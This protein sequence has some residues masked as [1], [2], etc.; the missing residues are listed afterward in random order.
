[1]GSGAA[2]QLD[3]AK[4]VHAAAHPSLTLFIQEENC[5]GWQLL[6]FSDL[7][8]CCLLMVNCYHKAQHLRGSARIEA[9]P[10]PAT[11]QDIL[12]SGP[13]AD[14]GDEDCHFDPVYS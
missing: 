5:I 9:S 8:R 3:G 6:K 12:A 1:M 7:G 14:G 10:S 4:L 13:A 11:T 2:G